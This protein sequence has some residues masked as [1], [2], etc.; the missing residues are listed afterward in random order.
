MPMAV[1]TLMVAV[2][3]AFAAYAGWLLY[4]V[5]RQ[6]RELKSKPVNAESGI[7]NE[8]QLSHR[9]SIRVL[10]MCVVQQQVSSTE[11]AIR[12]TALARA[13]PANEASDEKYHAFAELA[14]ATA[15]IPVLQAWQALEKSARKSF[16]QERLAIEKA[17]HNQIMCAARLILG[18][19]DV[20]AH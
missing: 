12:I 2:V 5:V 20:T 6:R 14:N 9:E 1:T 3:V 11:A 13:L 18:Q 8:H 16:E 7:A 17:H 15:H 10:A 19:N 4:R